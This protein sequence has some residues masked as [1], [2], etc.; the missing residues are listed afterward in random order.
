MS[1]QIGGTANCSSSPAG[2]LF[3]ANCAGDGVMQPY[4]LMT[5][6]P[7]AQNAGTL[8]NI[9]A[10]GF[11]QLAIGSQTFTG[12]NTFTDSTNS[13]TAF[14]IDNN[15]PHSILDVD[16]SANQVVFGNT[17]TNVGQIVFDDGNSASTVTINAANSSATY[18]LTLPTVAPSTSQCLSSGAVTAKL[19]V[20]TT[21]GGAG[22]NNGFVL[23][24]N[25]SFD[26]QST[27]GHVTGVLEANGADTLDL[28]N[29]GAVTVES[30]GSTGAALFENSTNS[31]TAFQVQNASGIN[32]LN[33]DTTNSQVDIGDLSTPTTPIF[34]QAPIAGAAT[35]SGAG[36]AYTYEITAVN[37]SG[38]ESLGATE[39]LASN[40]A[41]L[42]T[43]PIT[44]NWTTNG[45]SSYKIYRT[46]S[47]GTPSTTGLIG[48]V[49]NTSAIASTG[50]SET[51]TILTLKF[52]STPPWAV[53]QDVTLAGFT[54]STGPSVNGTPHPI[55]SISGD[56][57]TLSISSGVTANVS[58]PGTATGDLGFQD[59]GFSAGAAAPVL[60]TTG[61]LLTAHTY[62]YE[63]TALDNTY[64]AGGTIGESAASPQLAATTNAVNKSLTISWA[65]VAGARAYN[66]YRTIST[67]TY[68]T[69]GFYYTVY[70]NSFTDTGATSTGTNTTP[71]TVSTAYANTL[72]NNANANVTIGSNGTSTAQL[73]VG[74]SLPTA[75]V[76]TAVTG[77]TGDGNTPFNVYVQG[78]YLYEV[79]NNNTTFE[80]FDISNPNNPVQMSSIVA[81][82]NPSGLFVLGQYAYVTNEF[83]NT[84][85]IINISNPTAP[86]IVDT[87]NTDSEPNQVYVQGNYA[88]VV[89]VNGNDLQTFDVSNPADTLLVSTVTT[90]GSTPAPVN[91]TVQG[92]YLY[93]VNLT[94]NTLQ[95]Y[96][97]SNPALPVLANPTNGI[98][99]G[100]GSGP[101]YVAVS[102]RYAYVVDQT[103]SVLAIYDISNPATVS[104]LVGSV[105]TG[106]TPKEVAV[107]GNYA[108]V[109]N[110]SGNT[111][112]VFNISNP[113][114][115]ISVGT[116]PTGSGGPWGIFVQGNYLY[117]ADNNIDAISI[118]NIGGAY[119]QQLQ[120]GG[121]EVGSLSVDNNALV[122]GSESITGGL[123]VSSSAAFSA[124]LS[125]NG[126]VEVVGAVPSSAV[127][128]VTSSG[129]DDL[130]VSGNYT[131]VGTAT[132][133]QVFNTSVPSSPVL[134]GYVA[135]GA[136][137]YTFVQGNYVYVLDDSTNF[138]YI[139]NISNPTNPVVVNSVATNSIPIGLYVSGH[140]AYVATDAVPSYLDIYDV[141]IPAVPVLVSNSLILANSARTLAYGYTAISVQGNYA[142]IGAQGGA[143][144]LFVV[145]V[146]NPASP[147][148]VGYTS[149]LNNQFERVVVQG[150]YAYVGELNNIQIVDISIPSNPTV[151]GGDFTGLPFIDALS[152]QGHYL[153]ALNHNSSPSLEEI[154]IS[155]PTN[156]TLVNSITT[157]TAPSDMV[158]QGE[159]AYVASGT[160]NTLQIFNIGGA[161]L[162]QL[163]AG[164]VETSTLQ[165]DGYVTVS[166]SA[167]ITGGL[168][169]GGATQL[170]STVSAGSLSITDGL[171][172]P[173][174]PTQT[175][176]CASTC[177]SSYSYDV[178]ALNA[179]GSS[180]VSPT[181]TAA[182]ANAALNTT[183]N[184]V[185]TSWS[186]VAGATSYNVYRT[187]GGASQGLI[188]NVNYTSVLTPSSGSETGTV[189]TLNFASAPPWTV[190]Q[191]ITLAGFTMSAGTVNGTWPITA[192]TATS[193][194]VNHPGGVTSTISVEGTATGALA[195]YDTAQAAAGA[196]PTSASAGTITLETTST[197][198]FLAENS[199]AVADL[200]VDTLDGVVIVG[201]GNSANTTQTLLQ[202]NSY[203]AGANN[204]AD[205]SACTTSTDQGALYYN[206][207]TNTVRGCINGAWQDLVSTQGL[208]TLLFG[209]VP[210]SGNKPGDLI[211]S[212]ATAVASSNTGGPCKVNWAS[213]TSVY[214]N[215]CLAY[216]GGREVSVP[217]TTIPLTG[218]AINSYDDIC[219][220]ANGIPAL[221]G[222]ASTTNGSQT[223]NTLTI[224]NGTTYGQPLLCLA[225][226][227][228]SGT[229]GNISKIYDARTFT[230]TTKTYATIATA[231]NGYLG[232]TVTP[233]GTAG[234]VVWSTSATGIVQGV[235]VA[236]TGAAGT[237]GTPNIMIATSGPQWVFGLSS[238]ANVL[239]D[240]IIP[241]TTG[242]ADGGTTTTG[243]DAYDMVGVEQNTYP[244]SCAAQTFGL[245]DCQ[246]SLFT[247]LNIQ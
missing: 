157:N 217:T 11:A 245:T 116:I 200:T 19:L 18:I 238:A 134:V 164:G 44:I 83:G 191:G 90:P 246:Y 37:A 78:N 187:A 128:S 67:G 231:A 24:S 5:S 98:S 79:N 146:A 223:F 140:Y 75:A 229:V 139:V 160:A 46:A 175:T 218:I 184:Y 240:F 80:I 29:A 194:T 71:P 111:I 36:T 142:Y 206:T 220:N 127:G 199:A 50:G 221:L 201:S 141:A 203:T 216:S 84:M 114:D 95:I 1:M 125:V 96:N 115:P 4:I 16:T 2:G 51:G 25:A 190:G 61:S 87:V 48:T 86:V 30:F 189:L 94:S 227:L 3:T 197:Q 6:T 27:S 166:G 224:T 195:F 59:N 188:G 167:S 209:V 23:Q 230:N 93:L 211:G 153:Y 180:A 179:S 135:V 233:S 185:E 110:N 235:V 35:G 12:S 232:A 176:T 225:T 99:T 165:V 148:Q 31:T 173:T 208:S 107:S 169:V 41:V 32:I 104:S 207:V 138:L 66:V 54:M 242:G 38:G 52:A 159:Y 102:G 122:S 202:I 64:V 62:D 178:T 228:T 219:L 237:N 186:A 205:T 55:L 85:V 100:S 243:A 58:T 8:G 152:V 43:N 158:V 136:L 120:A 63:I 131:Y 168:A 60:A 101:H 91:L 183:T 73:Y 14:Q 9:A 163:S 172:T 40:G 45:A 193:I 89:N 22:I 214:V 154:D 204:V 239:N 10:S 88:Y 177:T 26:I 121:E 174:L 82:N 222:G 7:Y 149:G 161:Y 49:S 57:M 171:T 119:I 77:T 215:S 137:N 150:N 198:A 192:V 39:T 69:T 103:T 162:Q 72:G 213:T 56:S 105:S 70:T 20:F 47:A 34:S 112:Q 132:G 210:N 124:G 68:A 28:K 156:P 33:T 212:S 42:S 144:G 182:A 236:S 15:G 143:Q 145:N 53:G 123:S 126:N 13:A 117:E 196:A 17:T 181:V 109:T 76:G 234:L 226:I 118:F 113:A 155:D 21:C 108:Y 74:G 130:V 92:S 244:T 241:T 106:G 129:A 151:V 170:I 147:F 97:I 65:P 247:Y 133:L 81:G